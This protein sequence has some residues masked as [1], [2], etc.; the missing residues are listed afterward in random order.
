MFPNLIMDTAFEAHFLKKTV[1]FLPQLPS[2]RELL[3]QSDKLFRIAT[4]QKYNGV[5]VLAGGSVKKMKKAIG[6]QA[7]EMRKQ[8]RKVRQLSDKLFKEC[9]CSQ[10]SALT[11]AQYRAWREGFDLGVERSKQKMKQQMF[12]DVIAAAQKAK[13]PKLF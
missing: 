8:A 7:D 5:K 12:T 13:I 3:I 4:N 10:G 2:S 1:K 9:F 11:N 6:R